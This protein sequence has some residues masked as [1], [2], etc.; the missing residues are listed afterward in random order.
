MFQPAYQGQKLVVLSTVSWMGG[1]N[2][3]LGEAYLVV[4]II[5]IVLSG[6]FFVKHKTSPRDLADPS[7]LDYNN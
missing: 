4:G 6:V 3:I 1:K 2:S 7:L 5:C